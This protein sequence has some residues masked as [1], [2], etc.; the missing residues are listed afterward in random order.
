HDTALEQ[1]LGGILTPLLPKN[2]LE[3]VEWRLRILRDPMVNAFTMP[4]GS[5]Y[6]SAG[7]LARME[8][9]DQLAAVLAHEVTHVASRHAYIS[10]RSRAGNV[11]AIQLIEAGTNVVPAG[12]ITEA[13]L[14]LLRNI[15]E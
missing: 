4:N 8:N 1:Q 3:H 5:I 15:C 9:E 13:T 10:K 7:L 14:V 2:P 11:A 6:V 12:G